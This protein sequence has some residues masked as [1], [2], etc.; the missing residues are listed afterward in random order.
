MR[1]ARCANPQQTKRRLVAGTPHSRCQVDIPHVVTRSNLYGRLSGDPEL[2]TAVL[3]L[4]EVAGRLADTVSRTVPA[5]TDHTIRHMDALWGVTDRVLTPQ[6]VTALSYGEAFLLACG[7]YL[8]DIGMAYAATDEGMRRIRSSPVYASIM[9]STPAS[10]LGD[11][12]FQARALAYAVRALHAEVA[13]ELAATPIPGTDVYLF[14][15]ASIREAWAETCGRVAASHHWSLEKVE[16][17]LGSTGVVPLPGGRR[18]DIGYNA[19]LLRQSTTPTLIETA[20]RGLTAPFACPSSERASSTGLPRNPLTG[21]SGTE[22]TWCIERPHRWP[23]WTR[24]GCTTRCSRG[25]TTRFARSGDTWIDAP[26]ARADCPCRAC[27][28]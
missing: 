9:A 1:A 5:F 28:A 7:F 8:H 3:S 20:R 24:G 27:V 4:R 16:R 25:L 10:T 12:S 6:E 11:A 19:S 23:T 13:S 14:D 21:R 15:S 18:G 17:E 2:L 26:R 22:P